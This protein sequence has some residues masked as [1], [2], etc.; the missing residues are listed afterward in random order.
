MNLPNIYAT[1]V[2]KQ[3]I[4]MT[5]SVNPLGC[6][7]CVKKMLKQLDA[8]DISTY[9]DTNPLLTSGSKRFLVPTSCILVG[10]GSEQ[11]IK[12]I[13]QTFLKPEDT[14]L[15]QSGSFSLFTKECLIAGAQIT[16]CETNTIADQ[17]PPKILFLCSPNNP[18]GELIPQKTLQKIISVFPKTIIII[19]EA[20]AE[21]ANQT[22]IPIAMA[23]NNILILRT[24]SKAFGLAGLRVGFCIGNQT[25][26]KT[27]QTNQQPFPVSSLSIKLTEAAL[28]DTR[29]L[30]T[31]IDW[32]IK[33]RITMTNAF[34]N[35]GLKVS[36]SVTNTLFVSTPR[37]D[38][39][40]VA[41]QA[42]GVS[43]IS[44]TF[45]P[46]LKT[47]GFRIALRD[48]KTNQLFLQKLDIAIES[49]GINLLR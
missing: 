18:T 28:K 23:N 29:F 32:V 33:E 8:R 16:L 44:N 19:D 43:V 26:I 7:P 5:L 4:D 42:N 24:C 2:K 11:L 12:L 48:K 35:R 15:V 49:L 13:T 39:L 10:S 27:L 38:E 37:A 17:L 45:F 3:R 25:L 1:A 22:S 36:N 40:I 46:G 30:N 9:P 41:L 31:T 20:N 47:P 34:R 21:F 14:A 6:S